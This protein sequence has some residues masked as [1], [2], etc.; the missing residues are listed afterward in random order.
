MKIIKEIFESFWW[1]FAL[2]EVLA[3]PHTISWYKEQIETN[4]KIFRN[5]SIQ[6]IS[7]FIFTG[8]LFLML[9]YLV[10]LAIHGELVAPVWYW[11][12]AIVL[13]LCIIA[14]EFL[15][16]RKSKTKSIG[17]NK[18]TP[19]QIFKGKWKNTWSDPPFENSDS[20]TFEI[21]NQNEY[22]AS[23]ITNGIVAFNHHRFNIINFKYNKETNDLTFVKLWVDGGSPYE[24]KLKMITED[25][26]EGME[27]NKAKV[28]Y[29]R[30]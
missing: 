4:W 11:W 7:M 14:Y 3:I 1:L 13:I 9:F 30:E 18:I 28:I 26:F 19:D 6:A 5:K 21:R 23:K 29:T 22:H 24:V 10:K 20:E 8:C 12:I 27:N 15:N 16:I 2:L 25:R 17:E